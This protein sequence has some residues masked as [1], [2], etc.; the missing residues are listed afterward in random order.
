MAITL[1]SLSVLMSANSA[2]LRRDIQEATRSFRRFGQTVGHTAK[3]AAAAY[4]AIA[5]V[6]KIKDLTNSVVGAAATFESLNSSLTTVYGSAEVASRKF[7]ELRKFAAETPYTIEEV[8]E[9]A[10][11]MRALGLDPTTEAL[12]SMGNTASGMG[13]DLMQFTE[14][15]ADAVTG[16]MERLKEFG[17]KSSKEGDNVKF[18]FQGITTTVKNNSE[19]IQKYLLE[20]G[21]TAFAGGMA[22]QSDTLSGKFGQLGGAVTEL[23]AT[24]SDSS[25]L[26][27][28]TKDATDALINMAKKATGAIDAMTSGEKIASLRTEIREINA[29]YRKAQ[30]IDG[31]T[32]TGLTKLRAVHD[33]RKKAIRDRIELLRQEQNT[34]I[35]SIRAQEE[36]EA[37]SRRKR[38]EQIDAANKKKSDAEAAEAKQREITD[39]FG[40]DPEEKFN[41]IEESFMSEMEILN[42]QYEEKKELMENFTKYSIGDAERRGKLINSISKKYYEDTLALS[43]KEQEEKLKK[44]KAGQNATLN[45]TSIFFGLLG[46]KNKNFAVAEAVMNAALGAV[47]TWNAYPFP[48]NIAPTALHIAQGAANVNAVKSRGS[49]SAPGGSASVPDLP[50]TIGGDELAAANDEPQ[51]KTITVAFEGDGELLPRSVLRELA[52]ELNSLDDS[53]VRISV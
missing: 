26:T 16:E 13:K 10:I 25:G 40:G 30:S 5:A 50:S 8:T 9:A 41:S 32:E 14:A 24:F 37:E 11:K 19:D 47:R 7:D 43:K 34:A 2:A 33:E 52:D 6:G 53:N 23:A 21:D 15:I 4:V 27:Q 44:I 36:A 1:A 38:Q 45:A 3:A 42:K 18:T 28:V 35:E 17:I 46:Q 48:W 29:E 49:V 31:M 22:R 39:T 12:T 20:L 51:T